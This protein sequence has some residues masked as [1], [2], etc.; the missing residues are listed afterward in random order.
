MRVL[1]VAETIKGGIATILNQLNEDD[2]VE[3]LFIVPD[4]HLMEMENQT[5]VRSF[6]RTGRNILSFIHLAYIFLKT[7]YIY[8]PDILHIHSS[9]AGLICRMMLPFYIFKVKVVYCPHAFSFLMDI[10]NFK[11]RLFSLLEKFLLLN[12]D[13]IICTSEY[14]KKIAISNGL[15]ADKLLV[16][17][18]GVK[19]PLQVISE[20]PYNNQLFNILFVGR[21]DKQKAFDFVIE[22]GRKLPKK[23]KLT[24]VGDFV[25]D[26]ST[27]YIPKNMNH[28]K[29]LSRS[30]LAIYY[31]YADLIFMPSR[32]ES[33][34]LVAVEANSYGTPVLA[35][36]KSSLPEIIKHGFNGYVFE[37]YDT[38]KVLE[39]IEMASNNK[40]IDLSKNCYY[41]YSE[42]FNQNVMLD[43]VFNLY[44]K[45][46]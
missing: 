29:W 31:Y 16:I 10:G 42:K 1:H 28:I 30:E 44:N 38:N 36:N 12:T 8:R 14:E 25:N 22:I 32:W 24:I 27:Y 26:E 2:R 15:K 33:F 9:F 3:T 40:N 21:F 45:L 19:S 13:K 18:N 37:T 43:K 39:L 46:L 17:Y 20:N 11:K 4:Q 35:S 23:F 6:N 7:I 34:G 5:N 41:I